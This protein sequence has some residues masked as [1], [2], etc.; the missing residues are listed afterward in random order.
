MSCQVPDSPFASHWLPTQL[1]SPLL[2]V[3]QLTH[4][5]LSTWPHL[6]TLDS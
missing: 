4:D 2:K 1:T 5:N 3:P 6:S